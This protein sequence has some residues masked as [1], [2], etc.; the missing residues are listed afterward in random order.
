MN[1]KPLLSAAVITLGLSGCATLDGD[2]IDPLEPLNRK[3]YRFNEAVDKAVLKPVAQGYD[4]VVPGPIKTGVRNFFSNLNDVSVLAND[5]LQLKLQQGV[6]DFLRLAFN[7]TF[8]MFG[9]LDIASE[10]GLRKHEEDFGQTL[11][12]WG[13]GTGPYLVLPFLGPSN[14][15]DAVG[16]SV[17]SSYTDLV[18]QHDDVSIRNPVLGTRVIS[19]R[20][21]LLDASSILEAAALDPY[22]FLRDIYLER[23]LS[24]VHDGNPPE[25][26]E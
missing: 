24:L 7:S 14:F 9:L 26:D 18:W 21:E 6:S 16:W 12:Y 8:G 25:E 5:I 10:M 3:I 19:Q 4:A 2:P 23:R 1:P 22:E 11:G 17:D 20:A 13:V 15:R